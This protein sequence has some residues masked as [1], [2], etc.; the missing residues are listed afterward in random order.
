MSAVLGHRSQTSLSI[1]L[2]AG[3][4]RQMRCS[5]FENEGAGQSKEPPASSGSDNVYITSVT[6]SC[7][8]RDKDDL[9]A[10]NTASSS[11]ALHD[12]RASR[13]AF[14]CAALLTMDVP[15]SAL[16]ILARRSDMLGHKNG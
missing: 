9:L 5:I 10:V 16:K 6:S 2:I 8:A 13:V 11:S 15:F 14:S 7:T 1:P 4:V 3:D 12:L